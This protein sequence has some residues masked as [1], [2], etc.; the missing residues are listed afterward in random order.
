[1]ALVLVFLVAVCAFALSTVSG[2]GAGL[3][4]LP[5][6]AQVLPT[7][8]V[9][10]ALTVGTATNTVA[11]LLLFRQHIS[12]A[13][14]WLF[15]PAA[16][17]GA[18]LGAYLLK[19]LN[20]LYL[21]VIIGLFLLSNLTMLRR[22]AAVVDVRSTPPGRLQLLG[23]GFT[24]GFLSGLTGGVGLLFN[25]FYFRYGLTR[26]Q[27]IATRA[28]NEVLLH[29]IKLLLYFFL[30]LLTAPAWRIGAVVAVGAVLSTWATQRV[31]RYLPEPTFRRIGY[32]AMVL[33]GAFMIVA[34][35]QEL[36]SSENL[37]ATLTLIGDDVEITGWWR[38]SS[39][40]LEM[41][42]GYIP[43]I[44]RRV[45]FT[46]LPMRVQETIGSLQRGRVILK[47][48]EVWK[49]NAHYYEVYFDDNGHVSEVD[50]PG[51]K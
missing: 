30:G 20:P 18:L 21:N 26:D 32:A 5:V 41:E 14:T 44:E 42:S 17:P 24:A 10:G 12:W 49:L 6:L 1:M 8:A 16:V 38:S 9:P 37:R 35:V 47:T 51:P 19:Y 13:I 28:A 4:L 46:D 27:V 48:E 22:S 50:V 25:R 36:R 34:A 45:A 39:L 43:A 7:S 11:K 3:L 33:S 40:T 15:V 29:F 23:I 2:G 31:V